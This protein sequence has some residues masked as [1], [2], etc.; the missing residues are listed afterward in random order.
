MLQAGA[1]TT[2]NPTLARQSS[3]IKK[4]YGEMKVH[5]AE[6]T[7]KVKAKSGRSLSPTSAEGPVVQGPSPARNTLVRGSSWKA[8]AKAVKRGLTCGGTG[9]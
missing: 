1:S 3:S 9:E 6:L 5:L 7:T 8:A 4:R 2:D